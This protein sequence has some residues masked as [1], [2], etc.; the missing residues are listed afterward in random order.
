MSRTSTP[1]NS[2]E[3][4]SVVVCTYNGGLYVE[5]QIASILNQSYR[6]IEVIIAD[7]TSTDNTFDILQRFATDKR[8]QLYQNEKN[9]GYNT[10]FSWACNKAKG[11]YI[12]IA[13]QDDIWETDKIG[14]L[15]KAIKSHPGSVLVHGISARFEQKGNPHLRS[16][17]QL[18]LYQ[19]N[20]VRCFYLKN[21]ISGH[22]MLFHRSVLEKALPFPAAVYYDWWLVANA[23]TM[24]QI[25]AV[26]KILVWHRMHSSN[27]TGAAKPKEFFYQQEQVV[28]SNILQIPGLK[29]E[30]KAFGE[31]LLHYYLQLPQQ[32]FSFPLFQFLLKNAKVVFAYKK[33]TFPWVSYI[34][35]AFKL[36]KRNTIA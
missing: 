27:A 10:N 24:G 7:D 5:E 32:Q 19:G 29:Q 22:S 13:D 25:I 26:D 3:L 1:E 17:N 18:N 35:H 30:H 23:C 36:S 4:V 31:Q 16:I 20:D 6:A 28:L 33:R 12:A 14:V 11:A 15:V 9:V 21:A 2:S 8:V 34:K